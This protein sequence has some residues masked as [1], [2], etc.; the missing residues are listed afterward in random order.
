MRKFGTVRASVALG[1]ILAGGC[2][3]AGAETLGAAIADAY[4]NNPRLQAQRA[5]LRVLDESVIQAGAPYRLAMN[6]SG[7]LS[8]TEQRQ[9]DALD[10]FVSIDNKNFGIALTASQILFN[11]GRTASQV[12][13]AE[14]DVLAG[15][16]QLREA[17]NQ[18]LLEV[19]DSYVSVRRDAELIAIQRR[20]VASY[21]RQ[22]EQARVRERGGDLTRTDIAQ[23]EAQLQIIRTQLAQAEA[24]LEQSRARFATV[25]GRNPTVLEQEPPL[26]GM[27][28]SINAAYLAAE[29]ESP[30]LFQAILSERAGRSRVAAARAERRPIVTAQGSYGYVSPFSYRT[31][32]LG[33]GYSGDLT[34]TVPLLTRGVVDSQVRQ[35]I[36]NRQSLTF[37]IEDTRRVVDQTLLNAWNQSIAARDQL[38]AGEAGVLAAQAALDGVRRGF[39]EGFRSNFEVLDSEQRLLTAQLIVA[40]ARYNRY[41]GQ[42]NLLATLGRLEAAAVQQAVAAYDATA[43]LDRQRRRQF[44]PFQV[45]LQPLDKLGHPSG[46][47]DAAPDTARVTDSTFKPAIVPAPEGPLARGVPASGAA[48]GATPPLDTRDGLTVLPPASRAARPADA[49]IPNS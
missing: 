22:V 13:A 34:L 3:P 8:Y 37:Q 46:R 7:N 10:R 29:T 21:E 24:N 35:A 23:A 14:A 26:P 40:N 11:G 47:S 6:I 5:Q 45:V 32:D 17:E 9:R 43:N 39:S 31:R 15:R 20:S 33:R 25:V 16:E 42:A 12:S 30:T 44:G 48:P 38:A 2:G 19:V 28:V 27:P 36:A 4:R 18:I 1:Y 49:V 41:A